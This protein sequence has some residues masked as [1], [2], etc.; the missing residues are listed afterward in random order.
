M[1]QAPTSTAAPAPAWHAMSPGE[2]LG[3]TGAD[4]RG[5][6]SAE[7]AERLERDGPNALPET[8]GR[9]LWQI[10]LAQLKDTMIIVLLI[11]AAVSAVVSRELVDSLVILVLVLANA[12]I[13]TWQEVKAARSLGALRAMTAPHANALRD[14]EPV[15]LAAQDL[16]VGDVVLLAAG[17]AVPAD[18]RLLETAN[19]RIDESAL[20][21]ESHAVDKSTAAVPV[22]VALGDRTGVAF[23]A[24]LVVAGR[25]SGVVTATGAHT[26]VG[27]IAELI[28]SGPDVVTPMQRRL[29]Q[30][31]RTL[32]IAVLAVC[33]ALFAL[34]L[35]QGRDALETLMLAV[36]LAV[37][38]IPEGLVAISTVVLALGVQRMARRG[39]IVR[40]LPAVET[41]GST[42]VI[43]SDKTGTLT[44]NQMTATRLLARGGSYRI[45]G[46]GYSTVGD[47]TEG[48]L[49]VL[50]AKAGM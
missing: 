13:G 25:G 23:S 2:V 34:G 21:G 8:A 1:A 38:A 49:I 22:D 6:T 48:A 29:N 35:A 3:R 37:A 45:D 42:T 31:G 5:L 47:P 30:L 39:A 17:D 41:L 16:V 15:H 11:A 4:R 7:A 9:P 43:C 12:V 26:Q 40:T 46:L 36:A 14:G 28:S 33:A 18:L 24:T 20:T 44:L 10:V 27:G 50:A 32:G 19:L